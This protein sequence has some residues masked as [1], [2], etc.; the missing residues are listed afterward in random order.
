MGSS[1]TAFIDFGTHIV[2]DD[3][4]L[5]AYPWYDKDEESFGEIEDWYH[6]INGLSSDSLW[7]EYHKWEEANKTG[8]YHNDRDMVDRYKSLHPEWQ[9]RLNAYYEACG[10]LDSEIPIEIEYVGSYDY[11]EYILALKGYGDGSNDWSASPVDVEK[12]QVKPEDLSKAIEFCK[13]YN[14]PFENPQWY[15]GAIYG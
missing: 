13:K 11:P 6:R 15:I 2:P 9:E 1:V 8:D 14:I 7:D 10:K 3:D 12:L 5:T 4:D